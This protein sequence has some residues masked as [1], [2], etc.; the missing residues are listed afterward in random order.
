M[1]TASGKLTAL[2]VRNEKKPGRHSDGDNLYLQ[3][4]PSG[5]KSWLFLYRKDGRLREMGLGGLAKVSLATARDMASDARKTLALGLDP[6]AEKRRRQ[7]EHI[8]EQARAKTF[9]DF[10]DE[11]I[12]EH[13]KGWRNAKHRQQWR[14]T[15]KTHAAPLRTKTL[16]AITTEDVLRVLRPIWTD[17]AETASRLRGR[18][19]QILDAAK[20]R[21]LRSGDNPAE[22][23]G[24]LKHLLAKRDKS[25]RDHH[26]ALPHEE[27]PAFIRSLRQQEGVGPLALEFAILT[28]AR[29]SETLGA[30]WSEIDLE[31]KVWTIPKERMKASEEHDVPLSSRALEI[32][33]VAAKV[34][35]GEYVFPGRNSK[36]PLSSMVF[37]MLLRRAGRGDL[38]AHGFRSS[39]RDWAGDKT[40]FPREVAEMALAHAVG[41]KTERAY[42]REKARDKRRKLMDAWAAYCVRDGSNVL[43]LQ[44]SDASAA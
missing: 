24:N 11:Y 23:K 19:E 18:I 31:K 42:R 12:A 13:E 35:T 44:K 3:V 40:T 2:R 6:I 30:K 36:R 10:A 27:V 8:Q 39:F 1:A 5:A 25:S 21:N 4:S 43:A 33:A 20:A 14:N 7:H 41:D 34:R 16:D 38:T 32:L 28:A 37:L 9:G 15:L 29:T 26:S 22:W 17:K